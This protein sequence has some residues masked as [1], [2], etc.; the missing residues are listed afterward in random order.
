[1]ANN[2]EMRFMELNP[3]PLNER[4][5]WLCVP[6]E[7]GMCTCDPTLTG[8]FRAGE[9]ACTSGGEIARVVRA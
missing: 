6:L 8:G 1:M 2:S 4:L 7:S 9:Q 3:F 5:Q